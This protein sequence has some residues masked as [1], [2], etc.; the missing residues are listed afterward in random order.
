MYCPLPRCL[1]PVPQEELLAERQRAEELAA[2][3]EECQDTVDAQK[4]CT[5]AMH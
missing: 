5:H 3:L 4:P 2:A 1:T